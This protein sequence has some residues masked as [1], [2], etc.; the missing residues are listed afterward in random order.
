VQLDKVDV[1]R[2]TPGETAFRC[3]EKL[4]RSQGAFLV[5]QPDGSIKITRAGKARHAG[6][7][8]EGVNIKAGNA[9]H[10]WSNRHSHI[11]V[12]GQRPFGHSKPA[13]MEVQA[14]SEDEALRRYRPS[15]VV[16][17]GDIDQAHAKKRADY[18]RDREAGNSLRAEIAV[19]GFR[20]DGGMLWTPGHL[21]WLESPFLD[22]AQDMAIESV[23]FTQRRGEHSGSTAHLSLCDP[24]ALGGKKSKAGKANEAW[25]TDAGD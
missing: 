8:Y 9:D 11:H 5:G 16:H 13:H 23:R 3:V 12:R 22:I 21:V 24:R 14:Q 17:D 19:Q 1:A 20:D 7:L 25:S 2:I 15:L 6:G 10:N 4:C 18:R